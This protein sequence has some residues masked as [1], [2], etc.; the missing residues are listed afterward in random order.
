MDRSKHYFICIFSVVV[1]MK[2]AVYAHYLNKIKI[3]YFWYLRK[4]SVFDFFKI[5]NY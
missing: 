5:P 3:N 4:I 1:S 2:S